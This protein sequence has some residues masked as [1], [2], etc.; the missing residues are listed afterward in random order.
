MVTL[1][2]ITAGLGVAVFTFCQWPYSPTGKWY[3]NNSIPEWLFAKWVFMIIWIAMYSMIAT[4]WGYLLF[5]VPTDDTR[6]IAFYVLMVVH[7]VANKGWTV[8]AKHQKDGIA[9]A[10]VLFLVASGIAL[11]GIAYAINYWPSGILLTI[12]L[13]WLLVATGLNYTYLFIPEHMFIRDN[14]ETLPTYEKFD[15]ETE[16]PTVQ[17]GRQ[18]IGHGLR[19]TYAYGK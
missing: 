15:D 18:M 12:Y 16:V 6:H 7:L 8:A 3:R 19:K 14:Q 2:E 9:F 11:A 13:I 4:S 10:I 5:T 1:V 17:S